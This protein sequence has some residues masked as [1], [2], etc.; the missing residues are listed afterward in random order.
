MRNLYTLVFPILLSLT[1]LITCSVSFAQDRG[2]P[3]GFAP[4]ERDIMADYY[5]N[6]GPSGGI[7][8]PPT[9]PVRSMAEWEEIQS[10]VITWTSYPSILK[11]I[12]RHAKEQCEVIII[13]S[14][15]NSVRNYLTANGIDDTNLTFVVD[16][17]DSIWIRDYGQNT[18]YINEVDTLALVDWIYNRPRPDD[19]VLPERIATL[20]GLP[21]YSTTAA[22]TDLVHT[23][24]N[25]MSDGMG[26]AFSSRLVLEENGPNGGFNVTVKD[27]QTID[28]IM[29]DFMGITRYPKMESLPYDVIHHIDMH[30]KLLDEETLLVG[31]YPEGVADGPQ[32]EANI[33]YVLNNFNSVWGT[34][35]KLVRVQMPPD[36][37]GNY[38]DHNGGGWNAGDYRTYTNL[39]I[40]NELILVPTYEEVYDTT[41][42]R[43]ISEAM[44]GY[45]VVG[46]N[47]NSI[48][49][50]LGAIHCITKAVGVDD[51]LWITH[52]PLT[53]TQEST[54]YS[55]TAKIK[56][57][58][59]ISG[60]TLYYKLDDGIAWIPVAM[61]PIG[62]SPDYYNALI[63]GQ[64]SANIKYYIHAT[65]TTGKE[66]VRPL[67]APEGYWEFDVT[68][69]VGVGDPINDELTMGNVYPNP[70]SAITAIPITSD[71]S[72]D[73]SV[74]LI[75]VL[76]R[77][78][79]TIYNGEIPQGES[80]YFLHSDKYPA[81]TYFI[82]LQ[83]AEGSQIQ[84][85]L[86]K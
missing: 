59:G 8:T 82:R 72:F 61:Q 38:P 34:P 48:I 12:V 83:T 35:Y 67:V 36:G 55:V 52:Q 70:A 30:M 49:T 22:P 62:P 39:V 46:I 74:A 33:Q 43:I 5:A 45:D 21:I 31:E 10:L 84:K 75:D 68:P 76:G 23:G 54:D 4:F 41:A 80:H 3:A 53:D 63:P 15:E 65:A 44:P 18:I 19:D 27:E 64:T 50:A 42:L 51:P 20:K 7:T 32:I 66:Q 58:D 79:E 1:V 25:Y 86:I 78:I 6:R 85:L 71:R 29:N 40:V 47:C 11:E 69:L 24:G 37:N 56:H 13:C 60:A 77:T 57:K 16:D 9:S 28:Q 17:Y 73:A 2:L 26:T 81:G 14:S